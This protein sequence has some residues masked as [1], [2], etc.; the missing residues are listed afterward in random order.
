MDA[1]TLV[2]L[3]ASTLAQAEA[4]APWS[5]GLTSLALAR[6]L[7]VGEAEII[8]ALSP[9]L[10]RGDIAKRGGWYCTAAHVPRMTPE[11]QAFFA[12]LLPPPSPASLLPVPYEP[13][14]IAV[15]RSHV[16]GIKAAFDALVGLG[17][18]VRVG[19][20]IYRGEQMAEIR[21]RLEAAFAVDATLSAARFRDAIGTT[22]KY[23]V[24][25]LE[26][27]DAVGITAREGDLRVRR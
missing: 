3:A 19:D 1:E 11:Q 10:E 7:G 15:R 8:A 27:F 23:A 13:V 16:P 21:A 18:L 5:G 9:A 14:A 22:R 20:Q 6:V 2:A 26:F 25:L 12:D 4:D 24:P 17:A